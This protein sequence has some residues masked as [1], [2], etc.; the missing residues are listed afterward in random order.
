MIVFAGPSCRGV[1]GRSTDFVLHLRL[2]HGQDVETVYR[3]KPGLQ[4]CLAIW[5]AV[6]KSKAGM[7]GSKSRDSGQTKARRKA[8]RK[9]EG[10][11]A[12]RNEQNLEARLQEATEELETAQKDL[13]SFCFSVSHDLRAP[14]RSIDGFGNALLHEFG[15]TLEPQAREYLQRI[16]DS[17]KKLGVLIDELLVVSRIQRTEL[18]PE[19][20]NLTGMAESIVARLR[21]ADPQRKVVFSAEP[22]LRARGDGTLIETLLQKL[23]ENAWKFTARTSAAKIEFFSRMKNVQRLFVIKDNGVGFDVAYAGK[24]FKMFQRLHSPSEYSG[25]GSGLAIART[26]VLRH[27]GRIWTEDCG[28]RGAAF[29]FT[30]GKKF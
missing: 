7:R 11:S 18:A 5:R 6:P 17:S 25:V 21:Q 20:L 22:G 26:I 10:A 15:E 1:A 8:R 19:E 14:L 23:L 24:L 27:R 30:L 16:V 4:T 2:A 29:C 3:L 28:S 9:P 13:E 12:R